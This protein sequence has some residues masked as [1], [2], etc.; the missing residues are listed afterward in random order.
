MM[1]ASEGKIIIN[2]GLANYAGEK[3]IGL[4]GLTGKE[5]WQR[6]DQYTATALFAAPDGVYV[7]YSGVPH[8]NKYELSSGEAFW[9]QPL[10]GRG[11]PYLFIV[12]NEVHVSTDPF[13]F[14]KLDKENGKVL[15]TR[16][17]D[18]IYIST[19]DETFMPQIQA[20][21][22]ST[23]DVIWQRFDL[24]DYLRLAPIF[25]N[26]RILVRTG[27]ESGSIYVLDRTTGETLWKSNDNI[28]SSIAY[29]PR[30]GHLYALTQDGQLLGIDKD[31]GNQIILV[32]FSNIPFT[33][34]GKD[35]GGGYEI[36]FDG[37]TQNLYVLLG[38]SRQLFAFKVK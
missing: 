6:D 23:G 36:A 30:N 33:L 14:T 27:E 13:I 28:I 1:V 11:L 22:T 18:D 37:S 16:E 4:D 8:V 29:S 38:D 24:D 7:G 21:N 32:E 20:I 17:G 5:L 31:N 35:Q 25:L 10:S 12:D 9:S 3:I 2:G 34:S 15:Q 19:P 26:D